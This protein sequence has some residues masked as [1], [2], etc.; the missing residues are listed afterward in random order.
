MKTTNKTTQI[1]DRRAMLSLLWIFV[2]FNFTYGDILTLY[3]N[4]VLQKQA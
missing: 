4:T 2:M 1:K 3:F